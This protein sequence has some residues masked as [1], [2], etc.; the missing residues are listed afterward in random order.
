MNFWNILN[1]SKKKLKFSATGF[2]TNQVIT[3]EPIDDSKDAK[4]LFLQ[5]LGL[6]G[7]GLTAAG[8]LIFKT[9]QGASNSQILGIHRAA[10]ISGSTFIG[11]YGYCLEAS[12][13]RPDKRESFNIETAESVNLPIDEA[14]R[15]VNLS[16]KELPKFINHYFFLDQ[17]D[18]SLF[19]ED[20]K[21]MGVWIL[22]DNIGFVR[23]RR[24]L[25]PEAMFFT[26]GTMEI[27]F[28]LRKI[29]QDSGI[30]IKKL[31][32]DAELNKVFQYNYKLGFINE[33]FYRA[34]QEKFHFKIVPPRD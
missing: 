7:G 12:K 26:S 32:F 24:E 34:W 31:R 13:S 1:K 10:P 9:L 2:I 16:D 17:M 22:T 25:F 8:F 14:Y 18:V 15:F 3:V 20:F 27:L 28:W 30:D 6:L 4:K 5:L 23:V 29:L 11:L 21:Q 33:E 19:M